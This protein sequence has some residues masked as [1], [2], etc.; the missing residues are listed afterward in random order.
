MNRDDASRNFPTERGDSSEEGT[1]IKLA[2]VGTASWR[3][4][5]D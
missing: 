2:E 4:Q 1:N 5:L 3:T